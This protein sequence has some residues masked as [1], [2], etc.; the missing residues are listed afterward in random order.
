M[1][2]FIKNLFL[3]NKAKKILSYIESVETA[4]TL[5]N[6]ID[7]SEDKNVKL[8]RS[9]SKKKLYADV[10]SR[11][12]VCIQKIEQHNKEIQSLTFA[13][14]TLL[15][16]YPI[17]NILD[18][19]LEYSREK[20]EEIYSTVE[21]VYAYVIPNSFNH[22][23]QYD[24]YKQKIE[25][26]LCNYN[27]IKEQKS[28]I[29]TIISEIDHLPDIY[30]DSEN[31][32]TVLEKAL[33]GVEKYNTY[34]HKYYQVPIV[35]A[36]TI[37]NHNEKFISR[38]LSDTVFDNV[39]GKCLDN[40]QRRAVLCNAKSNLTIAG[41]GSGKTLTICGKVKYLLEMGL[42]KKEE[43]LLLSYS[44][45]SAD[46]LDR[47]INNVTT[48]LEVETFHALGLKILTEAS[49]KKKAIEEQLKA[50]ITQFFE[51]ELEKNPKIANEIFQY[52]AL[53]F[54]AAPTFKKKY[55]NDGEIFK[56]LKTLDFR[57]L[58]D[59][60]GKLSVNKDKHETL[61]NEFVKSNEELVIANYLFTNGINFN[62]LPIFI[63][64]IMTYM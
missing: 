32:P 28:L 53:Y 8:I 41:A 22:K 64:P 48:G 39:N 5:F 17:T 1:F 27:L 24:T 51:E 18:N 2:A 44:K 40:E 6:S 20:I 7:N 46:D 43:I 61:K 34:E 33:K 4:L 21:C 36:D 58:K 45:A 60:L 31:I 55:K 14:N 38:H 42:A 3:K 57:T 9:L 62:I 37:E 16:T 50:Y 56:E 52:I 47:K 54:Y 63:C 49:G 19:I 11:Y 12:N 59:R 13:Y 35:N 29:L 30:I 15:Q 10:V 23:K 25:E 26:I